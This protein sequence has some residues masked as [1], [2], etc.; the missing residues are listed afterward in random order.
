MRFFSGKF[1]K[2]ALL[3]NEILLPI[4]ATKLSPRLRFR[5]RGINVLYSR[6]KSNVFRIISELETYFVNVQSIILVVKILLQ[7]DLLPEVVVQLTVGNVQHLPHPLLDVPDVLH[8]LV[9]ADLHLVLDQINPL[10]PLPVLLAILSRGQWP[11]SLLQR[12][13]QLPYF[14]LEASGL[15]LVDIQLLLDVASPGLNKSQSLF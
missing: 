1:L 4:L 11:L 10:P 12:V 13:L 7:L 3:F 15:L 14:L 6:L 8:L 2:F 9:Q 5:A